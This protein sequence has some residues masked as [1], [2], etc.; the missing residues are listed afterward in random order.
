MGWWDD[1]VTAVIDRGKN[2]TSRVVRFL[3]KFLVWWLVVPILFVGAIAAAMGQIR[4][5]WHQWGDAPDASPP[6][7]VPPLDIGVW[8]NPGPERHA[9]LV[10]A[11]KK[12][13]PET[14][15]MS[16]QHGDRDGAILTRA[17]F[18]DLRSAGWVPTRQ[19][20]APL[21]G[22]YYGLWVFTKEAG[23]ADAGVSDAVRVFMEWCAD[24]HLNPQR[25][26]N[27]LPADN[28]GVEI[29]LADAPEAPQ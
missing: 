9:A 19:P 11:L 13:P 3:T 16:S 18:N 28:A 6:T 22:T 27:S 5:E 23:V 4:A 20:G 15:L 14:Y 26:P 2:S 24:E 10:A 17:I 29:R 21:S 7:P 12:L 8:R 25:S 1:H